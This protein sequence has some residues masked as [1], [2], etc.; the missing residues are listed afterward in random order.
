MG[1]TKKLDMTERPSFY[2]EGQ[3]LR[4]KL[5]NNGRCHWPTTN[6][7]EDGKATGTPSFWLHAEQPF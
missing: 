2:F 7:S 5:G 4:V 3:M 1:V 6:Y